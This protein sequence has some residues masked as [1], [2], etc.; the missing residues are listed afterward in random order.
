MNLFL[1]A[2]T[3]RGK[4]LADTLAAALDGDS[5][6]CGEPL[7]L[8]E[9]VAAHF[10]TGNCLI[11][12]GA[13]GIA[14]RAVAPYV[15]SKT[16]DPA[17]VVV[18]EAGGFAIPILS[19]HLGGANDLARTIGSICG[20]VPVLTTATDVNGVFAVDEW[21]KRQNCVIP[22][23][24]KIKEVSSLLLSGGTVRLRSDLPIAGEPPRGVRVTEEQDYD[25]LLSLRTRGKDVLR[26]VPRIAVLGVG[27]RRGAPR[28]AIEAALTAML[29]KSSLYEQAI[30]AVATIDL[31]KD[32]PGLLAFCAGHGWPLRSYSAEQLRQVEGD[33]TASAFV[34][35]VTGVDNVCERAA[36]LAANGGPIR[37]KKTAGNGVT[38]AVALMKPYH[39]TWRWRDE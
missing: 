31:K 29:G 15:R 1:I 18:D 16:A 5:V 34:E 23:A 10:Q 17:V 21:A 27:C 38:T 35:R 24:E 28:D 20:A 9:W 8:R 6:R 25:V 22:N 14:V 26:L 30:C 33:F 2:F 4:A 12:V 7:G 3:D 36:V 39:P 32:E 11:F 37:W 19:G 13:A